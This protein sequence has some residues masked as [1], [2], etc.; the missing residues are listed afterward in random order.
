MDGSG[1]RAPAAPALFSKNR[2]TAWS[3]GLFSLAPFREIA[4]MV[5]PARRVVITG[6]GVVS[7]L[8]T[9]REAFWQ[10][11]IAGRCGIARLDDGEG[12][13]GAVRDFQGR[14]DDFG[15]LE[16]EKKKTIRKGLKL[17]N[18][19]TQMA[20]AAAQQA[21][22]DSGVRAGDFDPDRVGVCFGAGNVS[23]LPEDFLPAIRK[24][25][26]ADE[27]F[28]FERWGSD[29]LTQVD[30]LWLLRYLPNMPACHIAIYNDFRGP[31][32]SITQREASA[33]LAVAEACAFIQDEEADLVVAGATGTMLQPINRI[34]ALVE[35]EIADGAEPTRLC[36]PFDLART[37]AVMG[38]GAAAFVLQDLASALRRGATIYG[39]VLAGG[40]SCVVERNCDPRGD[41]AVAN[42]LRGALQ[43][44]RLGVNDIGHLHAHGLGGRRADAE[45]ARGLGLALGD[46]A[47]EIPLVAAKGHL[48]NAGAGCGAL[49]LAASLLALRE[50][51]LFPVLNYEH[52]DPDCRVAPVRS[53]EVDAGASFINLNMV[54]QGEASCL[55]VARAA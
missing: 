53:P 46:R 39:E 40:S 4:G 36:R 35:T 16:P 7:P 12:C 25:S 14:I 2:P 33:N 5:A 32:N 20:V 1:A 29:G 54:S 49:E 15:D 30:P 34:H 26:D 44:A 19:Q 18:R 10:G 23:L 55:V 52:P 11:L 48:G 37:G 51:R 47:Q 24:C 21:L 38:E 9:T 31:N 50:R 13:A 41:L 45:E 43:R 6:L 22:A 27:R 3:A 17:M 28:H 42:A 8:G